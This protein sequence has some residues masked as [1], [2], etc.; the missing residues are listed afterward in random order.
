MSVEAYQPTREGDPLVFRCNHNTEAVEMVGFRV[1]DKEGNYKDKVK[2]ERDIYDKYVTLRQNYNSESKKV[3]NS[4]FKVM[5]IDNVVYDWKP[6]ESET[7]KIKLHTVTVNVNGTHKNIAVIIFQPNWRYPT[8]YIV[9]DYKL[10]DKNTIDQIVLSTA[11][12]WWGKNKSVINTKDE[13]AGLTIFKKE[14]DS[15]NVDKEKAYTN[16][17]TMK[18]FTSPKFN[19]SENVIANQM[20]YAKAKA[21]KQANVVANPNQLGSQSIPVV[22]K[23]DP[24]TGNVTER[25]E[26][27][28]TPDKWEH[29]IYNEYVQLKKDFIQLKDLDTNSFEYWKKIVA[30]HPKFEL[31]DTI[32]PKDLKKVTYLWSVPFLSHNAYKGHV[33]EKV[34]IYTYNASGIPVIIFQPS[35]LPNYNDPLLQS[36]HGTKKITAAHELWYDDKATLYIVDDPR[37]FNLNKNTEKDPLIAARTFWMGELPKFRKSEEETDSYTYIPHKSP[38]KGGRRRKTPSRKTRRT[39]RTRK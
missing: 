5:S 30:A 37:F 15:Y 2:W 23:Y 3:N 9:E 1:P 36:F 35:W 22:Y 8:L 24:N 12:W 19:A 4:K 38:K 25:K 14:E 21:K 32:I 18:P 13:S 16:P 29:V 7:V 26:G 6:E 10:L 31:S 27:L 39:R 34:R 20:A 11:K 17:F 28:R 33:K